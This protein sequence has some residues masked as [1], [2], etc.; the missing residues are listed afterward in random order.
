MPDKVPVKK[1]KKHLAVRASPKERLQAQL[2]EETRAGREEKLGLEALLGYP[3]S[4]VAEPP[5]RKCP[6]C[7]GTL[8]LTAIGEVRYEMLGHTW[9]QSGLQVERTEVTCEGGHIF[10]NKT[11]YRISADF[12]I[13]LRDGFPQ[14]DRR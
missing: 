3:P 4:G 7:H 11:D 13:Q 6:I 9:I 10:D 14:G 5:P 8:R 12:R 2:D 1:P